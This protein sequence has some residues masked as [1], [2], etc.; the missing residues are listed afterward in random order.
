M[1]LISQ[2]SSIVV[3]MPFAT[4]TEFHNEKKIDLVMMNYPSPFKMEKSQA[5]F[6]RTEGFIEQWK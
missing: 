3:E 6:I 4:L 2:V 1:P 5:K